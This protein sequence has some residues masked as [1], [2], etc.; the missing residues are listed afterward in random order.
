MV[1]LATIQ[2]S[3]L[4]SN[5]VKIRIYKTMT[6]LWFFCMEPTLGL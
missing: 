6:F 5:N 4:L 2:S 1:M 3:R